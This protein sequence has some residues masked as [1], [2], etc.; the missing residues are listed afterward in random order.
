VSIHISLKQAIEGVTFDAVFETL[1]ITDQAL[2]RQLGRRPVMALAG[3]NPHAGENGLMGR[4]EIEILAPVVQ[5]AQSLGM[6]VEG[7]ISPDTV[8]MRARHAPPKHEAQFDVVIALYHDQG[9]IP[10]KYMGLEGGVNITLG[11][12]IVRTSPDHGTAFDRVHAG[13]ASEE[14]FLQALGFAQKIA[15]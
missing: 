6:D 14:S 15:L 12:P 8:F 2:T 5:K 4:E 10:I 13:T 1:Q 9:L 3:L 7:P 11:L